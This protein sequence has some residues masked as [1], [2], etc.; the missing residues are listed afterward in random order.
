MDES[1]II[2]KSSADR[3]FLKVIKEQTAGDPMHEGVL[4]TNLSQREIARRMLTKGLKVSTFMIKQLLEKHSFGQRKIKKQTTMKNVA[5]RNKQF[6]KI[7]KLKKRYQRRGN[8]VISVDTKKKEFLGIFYREG[9][10]YT[11]GRIESYDHDFR[12]FATGVIVPYGIYDLKL[13]HGYLYLGTSR[14]TSEFACEN[15]ASWWQDYGKRK[16]PKATSILCLCDG[17]GSNNSRH[18]IFEEDLQKLVNKLG[19]EIRVAHYP[20]Y[21]SKYNPIEHCLFPHVT[22]AMKGVMLTDIGLVRSL[23]MNTNTTKGLSVNV[24]IVDKVYNK[25]RKATPEFRD[26]MPI[27]FDAILSRWNYRAVPAIS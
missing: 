10:L 27:L 23:I 11:Q 14:D 18:Y 21:C 17:G 19:I 26:N 25:G 2:K 3:M 5:E 24:N 22:R 4:W 16:Y 13:N 15:I 12:S 20:S 7:A 9:K 8:P 6:K 1:P